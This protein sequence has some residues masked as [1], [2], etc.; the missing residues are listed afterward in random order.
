[1]AG[2]S[3]PSWWSMY[4]PSPPQQ[5]QQQSNLSSL[6]PHH[7]V[8]G[9]SPSPIPNLS[10]D[11]LNVNYQE[12]PQS[13]SQLLLV[14]LSGGEEERLNLIDHF[15]PKKLEI[16]ESQQQHQNNPSSIANINNIIAVDVKQEV[17]HQLYGHGDQHHHGTPAWSSIMPMSN[18]NSPKSCVTSNILDF[19]HH[20]SKAADSNNSTNN[21]TNNNLHAD[22]YSSEC[23][24]TAT[25][26]ATKKARVQTSSQ[27]P[28]K[29]RKEKLGDRITALHQIV[30]PF[31]KTDTASVLLEA[32]GYIRFLQGQIEALSSPYM[33]NS[34]SNI[35]N[36]HSDFKQE[37]A[38]DLKS[39][40]LCL[41]PISCTQVESDV[42]NGADYW[43]P[44][45]PPPLGA[46]DG[47]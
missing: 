33:G 43:A 13:W 46:G 17:S 28:L 1:M 18:I 38:K 27:P 30:S 4:S 34:S 24:S 12:L 19:S 31:G 29:V 21:N 47:F 15:Q 20:N 42:I 37:K 3:N 25:G 41:V 32:I 11:D 14:G 40:G 45:P 9:S 10:V 36:Q 8:L 22:Q 26:G 16:W 2:G 7:Q 5:Q 23:N 35:R 39:R 6:F 44:A